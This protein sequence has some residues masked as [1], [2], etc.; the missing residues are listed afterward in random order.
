MHHINL[1]ESC[2]SAYSL[3]YLQD[4][5]R[6]FPVSTGKGREQNVTMKTDLHDQI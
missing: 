5:H 3:N 4:V 6:G 1:G 2:V